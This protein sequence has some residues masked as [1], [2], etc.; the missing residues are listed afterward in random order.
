MV[1]DM[2]K[3]SYLPPCDEE[4]DLQEYDRGILR[5]AKANSG[6]YDQAWPYNDWTAAASPSA[7]YDHMETLRKQMD[8]VPEEEIYRKQRLL[9]D[10]YDVVTV[11]PRHEKQ[12]NTGKTE[13]AKKNRGKVT[14]K[15]IKT[16]DDHIT[17]KTKLPTVKSAAKSIQTSKD[18]NSARN[19]N[20]KATVRA[21]EVKYLHTEND[22]QDIDESKDQQSVD[23]KN[24]HV[25]ARKARSI[26]H[27]FF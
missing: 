10:E 13:L 24:P 9:E 22:Y 23:I 14:S 20:V 11:E 7:D 2:A 26:W 25:S 27:R 8:T 18:Q 17:A 1:A 19:T 3:K 15:N 6:D 21:T 4:Y 5:S 16:A 12:N